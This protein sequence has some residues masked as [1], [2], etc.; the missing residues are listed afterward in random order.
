MNIPK[1]NLNTQRIQTREE[2]ELS[3]REQRGYSNIAEPRL[4]DRYSR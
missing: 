2:D 4:E 1:P 3:F